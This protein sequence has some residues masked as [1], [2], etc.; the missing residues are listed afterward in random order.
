MLIL[1]LDSVLILEL[2]CVHNILLATAA[3]TSLLQQNCAFP[4]TRY[5]NLWC[6]PFIFC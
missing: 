1:E 2:T 6:L 5:L 3:D 4:Q